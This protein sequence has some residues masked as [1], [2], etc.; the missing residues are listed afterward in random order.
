M[1]QTPETPPTGRTTRVGTGSVSAM[2]DPR[3]EIFFAAVETTRMPMT[4]TDP[5]QSDNPIIFANNAF[6]AMSGYSREEIVGRNCRFLQGPETDREAVAQVR[7]AIDERREYS[8][9][10]LNY[11]KDGSTF[12]NALFVSPLYDTAGE[13]LYFFAS[14]LDVSRR[15]DAEEALGQAQ[16]MEALGQLTGGIAHDFNNLLQVIVGYVDILSAGLEKPDADKGR[17]GRAADNIRQAAQRAT[18]LTQQLLAFSRKQRLEGRAV[19][20]N[21]LIEGMRDMVARSVGEAITVDYDPAPDLWNCR[22]D[23]TQAEVALLNVMINARD[24]MPE[25]GRIRIVTEN[26]DVSERDITGTGPLRAGRYVRV[27]ITDTGTGMPP[28]VLARVMD[29]FFT[30]KE[31]GKGTGLGLSM[32]YG[33]AK[34]SGGAAQIES[35][36][37][38]GTTVRLS[39]PVTETGV[40]EA[41][42]PAARAIER[43]G[44]ET[45]LIV[46]DREDVAELARTIL[47]DFGYVTLMAG[48]GREA[49]EILD[50]NDRIDMI[51]TDLIMPGGMNGVMLAREARRRQPRLKVLLTTGYAEASL[52]RTDAGGSEFDVLNKPYR[53]TDLI[54]RVRAVLDGPT[55]TG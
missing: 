54:R 53:R 17:L 4:V 30:T 2:S 29:P 49:L 35:V 15:R 42:K 47:R 34:Q 38:E 24:A 9:E 32:V 25:G 23:P 5:R 6:I 31:E 22:V 48:N 55:G 19:N 51:F 37:G 27:S 52:E 41:P 20:L 7:A 40:K 26:L 1:T 46:D 11:R 3:N 50:G 14:Q 45:I 13:L 39:F 36:Q 18:T 28:S 10:I 12:W 21:A 44:T 43:Q 16:K 33:F 8:T